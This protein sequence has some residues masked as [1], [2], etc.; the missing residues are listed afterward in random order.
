[1]DL[2]E[3]PLS[4][5]ADLPG[6]VVKA[7]E[8]GNCIPADA[9]QGLDL[10]GKAVLVH[11]GWTRHWGSQQYFSGHPFLDAQAATYLLLLA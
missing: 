6:I 8:Y 11:S 9:F 7:L 1:M 3:L 4:S 10:S 2:S 5:L